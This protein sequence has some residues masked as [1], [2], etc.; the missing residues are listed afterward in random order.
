M[1][2]LQEGRYL[3]DLTGESSVKTFGHGIEIAKLYGSAAPRLSL[4]PE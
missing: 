2:S 1:Q 4:K 3:L